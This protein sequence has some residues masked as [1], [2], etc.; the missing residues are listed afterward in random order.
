MLRRVEL[1]GQVSASELLGRRHQLGD[2]LGDAAGDQERDRRAGDNRHGEQR[3]DHRHRRRLR[4]ACLRELVRG[5]VVVEREPLVEPT[6]ELRPRGDSAVEHALRLDVVALRAERE[7]RVGLGD[8]RAPVALDLLEE[9]AILRGRDVL[10][11]VG[12]EEAVH[13]GL[14]LIE[15]L[16]ERPLLGGGGGGDVSELVAPV[17]VRARVDFLDQDRA[18]HRRRP[19]VRGARS[20]GAKLDGR[21]RADHDHQRQHHC[22]SAEQLLLDRETHARLLPR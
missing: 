7:E 12:G 4:R 5:D 15:L 8:V 6:L 16:R 1:D 10:A 14:H 17:L 22:E 9:R 20:D 19:D 3:E 18:R 13:L 11:S 21:D 2:A